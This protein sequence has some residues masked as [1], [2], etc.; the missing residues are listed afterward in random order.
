MFDL[1]ENLTR[2]I[3]VLSTVLITG[4]IALELTNLYA[5]SVSGIPLPGLDVPGL[6]VVFWIGRLA[7][8]AHGIE[9][10]IAAILA[11]ARSQNPLQYGIYTF[12][13]GTVGLAELFQMP[14]SEP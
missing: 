9:G 3:K 14:K 8:V 7:L 13:V 5:Q 6:D 11:P 12:F 1:K 10:A 2:P 4:A